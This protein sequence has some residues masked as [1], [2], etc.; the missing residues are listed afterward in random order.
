MLAIFLCYRQ[1]MQPNS[2]YS[3]I[4]TA[5]LL[6]GAAGLWMINSPKSALEQL[7]ATADSFTALD[8]QVVISENQPAIEQVTTRQ[9]TDYAEIN[10][11]IDT[12]EFAS[13]ISEINK[14]YSSLSSAE[15]DDLRRTLIS[16]ALMQ[17]KSEK[18]RTLSL[19]SQAFDDVL[20]WE[21]LGDAALGDNDW[22]LAYSAQLRASELQN[23]PI[24][25]ERLLSKLSVS[26]SHL[27][28]SYEQSDDLIG[29]RDLYQDLTDRH[30]SFSRFRYELAIS[31][32]N[33]GELEAAKPILQAL[34][35]DLELGSLAQQ[36]LDKLSGILADSE[37]D[38][39]TSTASSPQAQARS[40][41]L[42]V[43]LVKV[44]NSFMIN[45]SIEQSSA[46]LLLDTGASIT[47]L[48]SAFIARL[49]LSDTGR[50]ISLNTANGVTRAKLYRVRRL[51]LGSVVLRDMI[52]AEIGLSS[53]SSFQGLLGTDALNQ[54]APK[55]TYLIDNQKS[56][57]IFSQVN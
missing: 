54:L 55:Y 41:D 56:E 27:R 23:D 51:Q 43:P 11:L 30:P 14:R 1:F 26:S 24:R 7:P 10:R 37:V 48:S 18:K 9:S 6:L 2:F 3:L 38:K 42:I 20:V 22:R 52:V 39:E 44:G 53:Q 8:S 47:S 49:G 21:L 12:A 17:T 45:S 46:R 19:I 34:S 13:A 57:L 29:I 50:S 40:N 36:T 33:L 4:L 35:Y 31:M 5:L 16:T 25:L 28:K 15:L 32:V